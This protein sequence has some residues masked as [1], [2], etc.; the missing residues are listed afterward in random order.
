MYVR[1]HLILRTC[2]FLLSAVGG[3]EFEE[4]LKAAVQMNVYNKRAAAAANLCL[5]W[6]QAIDVSVLGSRGGVFSGESTL[7][8]LILSP[9]TYQ[10]VLIK[11]DIT[12]TTPSYYIMCLPYLTSFFSFL[13]S[14]PPPPPLLL[15][16]FSIFISF[17]LLSFLLSSDPSRSD[18][19]DASVSPMRLIGAIVLP[20]LQA[21]STMSLE[22]IM[23]EQV[24]DTQVQILTS[25]LEIISLCVTVYCG[26]CCAVVW[27]VLCGAVWC[28][29]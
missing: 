14:L 17:P 12:L 20:V 29:L 5:A 6:S 16:L 3:A 28:A 8:L 22:M 19:Q 18:L 25:L 11:I 7:L 1:T 27:C 10:I 24:R 26:V 13:L 15:L 23:A 2:H 9:I 21:L 4:A